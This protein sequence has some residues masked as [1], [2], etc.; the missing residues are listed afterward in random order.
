MRRYALRVWMV[1]WLVLVWILLWGNVSPA[2]ILSGLAIALVIMLLLPLPVVPV[3]G[4][5]HCCRCCGSSPRSP[6]S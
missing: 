1:C 5:V 6:T 2:N 4:R 3:E